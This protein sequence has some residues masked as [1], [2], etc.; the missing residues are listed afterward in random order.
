MRALSR[1]AR[2]LGKRTRWCLF[3]AASAATA[4]RLGTWPAPADC[5]SRADELEAEYQERFGR[6][7]KKGAA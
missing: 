2:H 3:V 4:N 1:L 7:R 6:K 5:A